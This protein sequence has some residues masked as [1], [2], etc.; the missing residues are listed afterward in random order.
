M[1]TPPV[2]DPTP[3]M[4]ALIQFVHGAYPPGHM[5]QLAI[6]LQAALG[7]CAEQQTLALNLL[8]NPAGSAEFRPLYLGRLEMANRVVRAITEQLTSIPPLRT[9][10]PPAAETDP[11]DPDGVDE[12]TM[13]VL[14]A[15][16]EVRS[17]V[18]PAAAPVIDLYAMELRG[19]IQ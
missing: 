2:R 5:E 15:L 12:A 18:G 1:S 19:Q 3:T 4:H 17:R 13:C 10:P 8:S 7:T 16:A 11:Y 6:A 14:N 9:G